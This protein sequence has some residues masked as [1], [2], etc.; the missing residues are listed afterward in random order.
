MRH[1][2]WTVVT[3]ATLLASAAIVRAFNVTFPT[4]ATAKAVVVVDELGNVLF[5]SKPGQVEVTSLPPTPATEIFNFTFE[6]PADGSAV[7]SVTVATVPTDRALLITDIDGNYQCD[8]PIGENPP[9][10]GCD[11]RD[12]SGLRL[13]WYSAPTYAGGDST[14]RTYS[15]GIRFSPGETIIMQA[16]PCPPNFL[17]PG[18]VY[19]SV[20]F[21]GRFVTTS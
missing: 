17:P 10:C 21:M 1:V 6:G 9:S 14:H 2:Q 16:T 8:V 18:A 4:R 20:T 19:G 5:G 3:I 7:S 11:L 12:S 13:R 15:T